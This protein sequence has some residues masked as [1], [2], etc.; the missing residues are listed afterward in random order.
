ML[1]K[2]I[3]Q[4]EGVDLSDAAAPGD[5]GI[6]DGKTPFTISCRVIYS[7]VDWRPSLFIPL[8]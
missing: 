3:Q 6:N 8:G 5:H 7:K 4:V 1:Q 2:A